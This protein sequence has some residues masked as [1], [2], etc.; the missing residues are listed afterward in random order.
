MQI[1]QGLFKLDVMDHHAILGVSIEADSK[2]IRKR[3][4]NIARKLHP[5]SL[6]E[7][8]EAQRTLASELL[9]QYVNPAYETLT[10]EKKAAEHA[11][12][13]RLKSEQLKRQPILLSLTTER[14]KALAGSNNIEYD[15]ST[16]LRGVTEN[17]FEALDCIATTINEISELNAIYLMRRG[18][19]SLP[20]GANGLS[21][22]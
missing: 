13:L 20:I 10:Q 9:S 5:D 15:Y 7:A 21:H 11:V 3:Y 12:I 1:D 14:S 18:G 2:Q 22:P 8:T 4:L 19:G 17:Q 6:R 16:A